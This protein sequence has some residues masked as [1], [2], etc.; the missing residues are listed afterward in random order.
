M[1]CNYLKTALL[2][3]GLIFLQCATE[4]T[5]NAQAHS[6]YIQGTRYHVANGKS[7]PFFFCYGH[8]IPVDDAI[9]RKKLHVVKVH[10]PD[11]TK[12][13]VTLRNEKSLHSYL[14][15][16]DKVGTYT[17][18]AE[19]TPGYFT[20]WVD[21]KGRTRHAIKP[22]SAV[23]DRASKIVSSTRSSQWTKTYIECEAPSPDFPAIVG[24]PLE[25]VPAS[26]PATLKKGDTAQF[27]VFLN[28]KPYTGEGYWDATY[29]GHSTQAE[30]YYIQRTHIKNGS[31]QFPID[32]TGRWFVRFFLKNPA[33]N[34][35]QEKYLNKKLTTTLVFEIPN[36]RRKPRIES[37]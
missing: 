14:V 18:T 7:S 9:R 24:L 15:E 36:A 2:L 29:S 5:T 25:I 4:F 35:E 10:A 19:T 3:T 22:M 37:H 13:D 11:G 27:T 16:Y 28:G 1:K 26:N 23:A 17:I 34:G 12:Y 30:D 6:L 32:H 31:F 20:K 8:H 21:K 33:A